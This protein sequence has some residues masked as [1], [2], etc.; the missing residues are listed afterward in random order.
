M[1]K[2]I[3]KVTLVCSS[4]EQNANKVWIGELYDDDTVITRWGRIRDPHGNIE[5]QL[6]SKTFPNAGESFLRKYA[7]RINTN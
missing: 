4:I 3:E 6:D 5:D 7:N 1:A 2:L